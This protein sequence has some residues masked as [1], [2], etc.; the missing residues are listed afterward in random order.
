MEKSQLISKQSAEESH[1][2]LSSSQSDCCQERTQGMRDVQGIPQTDGSHFK[3]A[4]TE[5]VVQ[6]FHKSSFEAQLVA[7]EPSVSS[8]LIKLV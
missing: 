3:G 4:N 5:C 1:A 2:S 6:I 8:N 7:K